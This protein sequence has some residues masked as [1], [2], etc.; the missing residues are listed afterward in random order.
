MNVKNYY[1]KLRQLARTR[2]IADLTQSV[3]FLLAL[4]AF[5]CLVGV[6]V[7]LSAV[8]CQMLLKYQNYLKN[9]LQRSPKKNLIDKP[10]CDDPLF[11]NFI[12]LTA[13]SN[14]T[15]M[16]SATTTDS[17]Y[18][19][20]ANGKCSDTRNEYMTLS[21]VPTAS[22]ELGE[23]W[24]FCNQSGVLTPT[25]TSSFD[26]GPADATFK[27]TRRRLTKD[28]YMFK[29][30]SRVVVVS[31]YVII[32]VF[33]SL[34]LTFNG[35]STLFGLTVERHLLAVMSTNWFFV[36]QAFVDNSDGNFGQNHAG[37]TNKHRDSSDKTYAESLAQD[38]FSS[39]K[40]DKLNSNA[41]SI[42][43]VVWEYCLREMN[44]QMHRAVELRSACDSYL[45]ELRQLTVDTVHRATLVSK[46]MSVEDDG[47]VSGLLFNQFRRTLFE[48]HTRIKN[49]TLHHVTAVD[50]QLRHL[51]NPYKSYLNMGVYGNQWMLFPLSLFNRSVASSAGDGMDPAVRNVAFWETLNRE[52]AFTSFL[53]VNVRNTSVDLQRFLH[54]RYFKSNNNTRHKFVLVYR[55]AVMSLMFK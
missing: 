10:E 30:F 34:L 28:G 49:A 42:S 37:P 17:K 27:A 38:Y 33:G 31:I 48:F 3:V 53:G 26:P 54:H 2:N 21:S 52:V 55:Y 5:V 29:R 20:V 12:L 35:L 18:A 11:N 1:A 8:P 51:T 46:S 4:S 15:T 19:A 39:I 24:R 14:T 45:K 50:R 47:L 7:C 6:C 22:E 13:S 9:G 36:H 40:P 43:T 44:R 41:L 32:N 23:E 25:M 16:A